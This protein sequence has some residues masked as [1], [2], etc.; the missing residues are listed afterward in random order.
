MDVIMECANAMAAEDEIS[1]VKFNMIVALSRGGGLARDGELPWGHIS[2]DMVRFMTLTTQTRDPLRKPAVIMGRKT[3]ESLP[4]RYRP[5]PLRDNLIITSNPGLFSPVKATNTE[6]FTFESQEEVIA[7]CKQ[8][9]YETAWIIGGKEIYE[10]FLKGEEPSL[11]S[12][13]HVTYIDADYQ[14][15]SYLSYP[16]EVDPIT[17]HPLPRK[18]EWNVAHTLH[19]THEDQEKQSLTLRTDFPLVLSWDYEN[20]GPFFCLSNSSEWHIVDNDGLRI[21]FLEYKRFI[22]V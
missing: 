7:H 9:Q 11:I 3:W 18:F 14:C 15:T 6:V 10:L 5:L 1:A 13:I 16:H 21:C 12:T 8:Q 20:D 4:L 19:A 17:L 22:I 2:K